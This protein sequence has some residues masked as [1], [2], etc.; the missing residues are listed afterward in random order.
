[1]T[2][3]HTGHFKHS[4]AAAVYMQYT[5]MPFIIYKTLHSS[6]LAS[7]R[8]VYIMWLNVSNY[9][10]YW[11]FFFEEYCY[12]FINC[13]VHEKNRATAKKEKVKQ[14]S[15]LQNK[16]NVPETTLQYTCDNHEIIYI[17][18]IAALGINMSIREISIP[19]ETMC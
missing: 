3:N 2:C 14:L 8:A 12:K 4:W 7:R 18:L 9:A 6:T 19:T 16:I 13:W 5:C 1:M 10:C 17:Q 11:L 15:N